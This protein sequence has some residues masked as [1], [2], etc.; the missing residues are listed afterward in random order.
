MEIIH[1]RNTV[2]D[3]PIYVQIEPKENLKNI[4]HLKYNASKDMFLVELGKPLSPCSSPLTPRKSP[5]KEKI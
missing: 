5:G 3:M 1:C 4:V 2:R